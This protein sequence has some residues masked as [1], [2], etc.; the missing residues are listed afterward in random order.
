MIHCINLHK[1]S[2]KTKVILYKWPVKCVL[3]LVKFKPHQREAKLILLLIWWISHQPWILCPFYCQIRMDT[4]PVA[5]DDVVSKCLDLFTPITISWQ[6]FVR[7]EAI[8]NTPKNTNSPCMFS[9][10]VRIK[11]LKICSVMKI[12]MY[13][14]LL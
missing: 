14:I 6:G 11:N 4:N 9:G 12:P 13:E 1:M 2:Q 5:C 8:F 7:R 3:F 10:N